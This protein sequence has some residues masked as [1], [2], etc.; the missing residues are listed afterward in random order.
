MLE[1]AQQLRL[2][3]R[4][5]VL[6][7]ADAGAVQHLQGVGQL[8]PQR[9]LGDI[10]QWRTR[11]HGRALEGPPNLPCVGPPRLA[12]WARAEISA[13]RRP[14]ATGPAQVEPTPASA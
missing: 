6:S 12:P 14:G 13:R 10:G 7:S 11:R 3:T 9:Q 8:G 5:P 4:K 2:P 1:Q